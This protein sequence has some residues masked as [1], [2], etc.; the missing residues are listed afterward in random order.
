MSN[1]FY[2][3]LQMADL[4]TTPVWATEAIVY[5]TGYVQRN[6]VRDAPLLKFELSYDYLTPAQ[7]EGLLNFFHRH[8]GAYESFLFHDLTD[9]APVARDFGVGDGLTTDFKLA[10]DAM[11][12]CL[13]YVN[14]VLNPAA[15]V[16]LATG[17]VA[18][19]AAPAVDARLTYSATN[20]RYRVRFLDDML[21]GNRFK[22]MASATQVVLMQ[23]R[24]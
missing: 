15:V 9:L 21:P 13:I 3:D 4:V 20:A 19:P 16:N 12:A 11:D 18:F 10:H 22:Y 2:P 14:A 17:R 5:E 8:R 6:A 24:E 23:V 7:Y 1:L